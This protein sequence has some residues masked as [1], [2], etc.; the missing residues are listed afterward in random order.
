MRRIRLPRV[1]PGV[2]SYGAHR[3]RCSRPGRRDLGPIGD[4]S[5]ANAAVVGFL[6]V[7]TA[8]AS[9]FPVEEAGYAHG[10]ARRQWRFRLRLWKP[11]VAGSFR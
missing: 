1:T 10:L 11:S 2:E 6:V 3:C 5:V 7:A 9:G 4:V 8:R